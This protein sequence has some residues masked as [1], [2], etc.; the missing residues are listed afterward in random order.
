MLVRPCSYSSQLDAWHS[1]SDLATDI[2]VVIVSCFAKK[3]ADLDHPYGHG[4]MEVVGSVLVALF[5][6]IAGVSVGYDSAMKIQTPNEGKLE[7]Y[8]SIAA[9]VSI[10]VNEGLYWYA[11]LVGKKINSQVIIAN[12]WHH[13]TDAMSSVVSLGGTLVALLFGWN[14]AD[15]I[16]GLFVALM[17]VW[18][19]LQILYQSMCSLVDRIPMETVDQLNQILADIPGVEGYSDVRAREMGAFV[20][21]DLKLYVHPGTHVEDAEEIQRVVET[22]IREEVKNVTEVMVRITSVRDDVRE[23]GRSER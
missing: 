22:K 8:T 14:Y 2:V 13:R 23:R 6:L 20:V 21:V 4:R 11:Y 9:L 1:L 15:P 16:A 3:P 5:L 17:I 19:G 7:W 12:A 10:L 18:I